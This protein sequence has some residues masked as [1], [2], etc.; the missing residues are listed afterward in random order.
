MISA[1]PAELRKKDS[2]LNSVNVKVYGSQNECFKV[3]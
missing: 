1:D 2:Y 3:A